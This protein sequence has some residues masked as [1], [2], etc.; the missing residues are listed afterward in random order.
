M[1]EH[2][3]TNGLLQEELQVKQKMIR[4]K[5]IKLTKN[6]FVYDA[7]I[8]IDPSSLISQID[9]SSLISQ[10]DPSPSITQIRLSQTV[11]QTDRQT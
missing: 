5:I 4:I 6:F 9:P 8:G 7:F 10:I 1:K 3:I 11:G 2:K